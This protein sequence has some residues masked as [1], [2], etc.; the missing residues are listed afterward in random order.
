MIAPHITA[1]LLEADQSFAETDDVME[2]LSWA[3]LAAKSGAP[4]PPRIGHW[5]YAALNA[6]RSGNAKTMD[7]AM[8]LEKRGKKQPRRR[9]SDAVT[10]NNYLG[11]MWF[12]L[13]AGA[14][15]TQAAVLVAA[16]TGR[17]VEQLQRSYGVSW[18]ARRN[19]DPF[20]GMEQEAVRDFVADMLRDYPDALETAREKAAIRRRHGL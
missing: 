16:R 2:A 12:L 17:K 11:R 19:D 20:S 10:L 9:M 5:L 18:F 3:A 13:A 6:Y 7:A 15:R 4:L 1:A 8:G 14:D